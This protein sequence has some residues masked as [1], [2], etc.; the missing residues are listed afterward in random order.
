M[1]A[2]KQQQADD[3]AD[4]AE[5]VRRYRLGD[6]DDARNRLRDAREEVRRWLIAGEGTYE[7]A[8]QLYQNQLKSF[9]L[10][11]LPYTDHSPE[12]LAYW[13]PDA[14]RAEPPDN[15]R[16]DTIGK[17]TI[18]PP[19]PDADVWVLHTTDIPEQ[20]Y[21]DLQPVVVDTWAGLAD[22]LYA[23]DAY[24][25]TFSYKHVKNALPRRRTAT[26]TG[27]PRLELL[28]DACRWGYKFGQ[29]VGLDL[30]LED[31]AEDAKLPYNSLFQ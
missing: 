2:K 22:V 28:D 21:E 1:S 18:E 15:L 16:E 25:A 29:S 10:E 30:G 3:P 12:A 19:A 14:D 9:L 4:V 26:V 6:V 20:R 17:V 5:A 24:E 8:S 31:A 7:K 13:R 27:Y 23:P 11:V